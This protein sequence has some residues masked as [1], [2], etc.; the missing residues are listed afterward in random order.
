MQ[1][2][3]RN[4]PDLDNMDDPIPPNTRT[5]PPVQPQR[6]EIVMPV[7][8]Q[9]IKTAAGLV[10]ELLAL[11]FRVIELS[12]ET[13]ALCARIVDTSMSWCGSVCDRARRYLIGIAH[14]L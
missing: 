7:M 10:C 6:V 8:P 5:R 2:K 13:S 4:Q 12:C 11:G 9:A 3:Y 14:G 1:P